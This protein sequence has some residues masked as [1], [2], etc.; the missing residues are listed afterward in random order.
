[1]LHLK[2]LSEFHEKCKVGLERPLKK[3]LLTVKHFTY[4]EISRCTDRLTPQPKLSFS[5]NN[6][7]LY[8]SCRF[9]N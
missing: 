8:F 4:G 9:G 6:W 7:S 2:V 5:S 3:H 1:M